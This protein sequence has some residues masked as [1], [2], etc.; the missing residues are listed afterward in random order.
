M[1]PM[2]R[3]AKAYFGSLT[4]E[5]AEI[6]RPLHDDH[7]REGEREEKEDADGSEDDPLRYVLT[8]VSLTDK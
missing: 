3:R 8:D 7:V 1:M 2:E 4:N 5:D 6:H